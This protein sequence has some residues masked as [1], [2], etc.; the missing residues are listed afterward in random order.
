MSQYAWRELDVCITKTI[1]ETHL[2][3]N[4]KN[5][6]LAEKISE[7]EYYIESFEN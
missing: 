2:T 7:I 1:H 3:D 4:E 6:I 5:K